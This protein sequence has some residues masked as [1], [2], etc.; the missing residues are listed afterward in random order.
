MLI[1]NQ[2]RLTIWQALYNKFD[3]T[4]FSSACALQ[5]VETL[6]VYEFAHKAGLLSCASVMYPQ[7]PLCEAYT[8]LIEE[9]QQSVIAE[10]EKERAATVQAQ[11]VRT[12][13]DCGSCGGGKVL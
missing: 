5:G 11:Q 13:S 7:V 10:K 3:Y 6:S 1:N 9:H 2:Q 4:E 12:T 8:R